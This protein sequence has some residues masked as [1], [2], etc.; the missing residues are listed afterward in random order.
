V[1]WLLVPGGEVVT[2]AP[3]DVIVSGGIAT[4]FE[5]RQIRFYPEERGFRWLSGDRGTAAVRGDGLPAA[6]ARA[7]LEREGFELV[8]E[9]TTPDSLSLTV[10]EAGWQLSGE[11]AGMSGE[12]FRS[13]A[14][15]LRRLSG[16]ND[17]REIRS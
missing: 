12:T 6:M 10:S 2:G 7:V 13:L 17:E 14:A 3:E 16:G 9:P 15:H 4:A 8:T 5:G 1:V 11:A